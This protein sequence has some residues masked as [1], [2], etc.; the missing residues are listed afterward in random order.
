MDREPTTRVLWHKRTVMVERRETMSG[1]QL[2][3]SL[4]VHEVTLM[5]ATGDTQAIATES[6]AER[7]LGAHVAG[8]RSVSARVPA[9]RPDPLRLWEAVVPG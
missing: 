6:Y 5:A 4:Q 9:E 3:I 7:E 2:S 8:M 1:R